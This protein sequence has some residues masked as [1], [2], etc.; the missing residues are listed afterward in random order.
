MVIVQEKMHVVINFVSYTVVPTALQNSFSLTFPRLSRR[1]WIVF[2][3][4]SVYA[5]YQCWLSIACNRTRNKGGGTNLKVQI[6][7]ICEWSEQKKILNC[8]M[9]SV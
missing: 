4:W 5:K 2:P 1:K 7:I 9:Q 3:D 8:C 6:Q